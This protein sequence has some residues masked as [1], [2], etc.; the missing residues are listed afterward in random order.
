[1]GTSECRNVGGENDILVLALGNDILGDDAVGLHAARSLAAS[2]I[3]GVD[4]VESREAGFAL[5]DLMQGYHAVVIIDA[6][7]SGRVPPGTIHH[8][9]HADLG[10]AVAHSPHT[11]GLPELFALA[12]RLHLPFPKEIRIVAME[13]A[14][15]WS[16]HEGLS[17]EATRALPNL[18]CEVGKLT[19][20][21][22]DH[23]QYF[24]AS[25]PSS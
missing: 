10:R 17:M 15:P 22:K 23:E 5:L 11:V 12:G 13:I 25:L 6:M 19:D 1:M 9:S 18:V 8:F 21:L 20:I 4:I 7:H 16:L 24:H 2:G 3:G 14:D